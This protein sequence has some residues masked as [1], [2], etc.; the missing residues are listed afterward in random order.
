MSSFIR[1]SLLF[2]FLFVSHSSFAQERASFR[3]FLSKIHIST[4]VGYGRTQYQ[5]CVFHPVGQG[6]EGEIIVSRQ[7]EQ[8]WLHTQ[9]S[10]EATI[11]WFGGQA[12]GEGIPDAE[13][14]S[15][16]EFEGQGTTFPVSLAAHVDLWRKVRLG[17]GGSFML[18]RLRELKPIEHEKLGSYLLSQKMHYNLRPFFSLGFK[19]IEN[20]S[21]SVLLDVNFGSDYM[22]SF[23]EGFIEFT[24]L[25]AQNIGLTVEGDISED[26]RLFSRISCE[27]SGFEKPLD[28]N[29]TVRASGQK[30]ILLQLGLSFNCPEYSRCQLAGC[31]IER[32]HKHG[33]EVYRGVS[34]FTS[35]DAQGRRIYQN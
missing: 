31:K 9:N 19:F 17:V 34:I 3:T 35:S 33:G 7:G 20:S 21:V 13:V 22:Y 30:S 18:N 24:N 8:L 2:C 5:Y 23:E 15:A 32:K 29:K 4:S 11:N 1:K 26:F 27:K 16:I 10:K 6:A 25:G 28:G 14:K 12:I